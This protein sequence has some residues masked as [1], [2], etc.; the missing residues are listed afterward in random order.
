MQAR[1]TPTHDIENLDDAHS[2]LVSVAE[3][4]NASAVLTTIASALATIDALDKPHNNPNYWA[5]VRV[6]LNV[7]ADELAREELTG[8]KV[9]AGE[10]SAADWSLAESLGDDDALYDE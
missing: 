10:L 3:Q 9:F 1:S 7:L 2:I 4:G 8:D 6:N 5:E